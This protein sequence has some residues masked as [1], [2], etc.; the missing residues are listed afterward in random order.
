MLWRLS[1]AL[2]AVSLA[3]FA[4]AWWWG[5]DVF[6]H[7]RP[8]YVAAAVLLALYAG[9]GR[10]W[11]PLALAGGL[12]LVNGWPL[13]GLL[14]AAPAAPAGGEAPIRLISLNVQMDA[15]HGATLAW[16]RSAEAD[17]V[18]LQEVDA[19]WM[20]G[21][22]E[23]GAQWPHRVARPRDDFMGLALLSRWPILDHEALRVGDGYADVMLWARVAAP[24][25]PLDVV[26]AHPLPP[27]N[28]AL[29]RQRNGAIQG[30]ARR[31]DLFGPRLV[32]AGDF[33]AAPWAGALAPLREAGL[34]HGRVG[35]GLQPSWPA[36]WPMLGVPI[37][38]VFV[39]GLIV[40]DHR[41]GPALAGDHLPVWAA[42]VPVPGLAAQGGAQ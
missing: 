11:R 40:V 42:L 9:V 35:R 13:L 16:L 7:F 22:A 18:A 24:G 15:P 1:L 14:G 33:N 31:L 19:A 41:V 26:V 38:H 20:A 34:V 4:E 2:A 10:A 23:V 37:D 28:D 3:G 36:G 32:V 8:H 5:V 29:W 30:L 27:M 17:L 12:C 25:G 21:V 6:S 39:R